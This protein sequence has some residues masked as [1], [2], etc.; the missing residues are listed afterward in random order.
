VTKS[1]NDGRDRE[2][3]RERERS[4]ARNINHISPREIFTET[5]Q[6]MIQ[7]ILG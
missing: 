4:A 5:Q 1:G 6:K 7:M 3:E 2:R